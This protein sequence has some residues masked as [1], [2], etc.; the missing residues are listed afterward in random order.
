[1]AKRDKNQRSL[2]LLK[3]EI[4]LESMLWNQNWREKLQMTSLFR[5]GSVFFVDQSTITEKVYFWRKLFNVI[6]FTIVS[7]RRRNRCICLLVYTIWWTEFFSVW[8]SHLPAHI[9][10]H[11]IYENT[12]SLFNKNVYC[13]TSKQIAMNNK[14]LEK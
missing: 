8:Y 9:Q 2:C 7:H 10:S 3:L 5:L 4:V 12:Y 14:L 11:V 1:M 13:R 6:L